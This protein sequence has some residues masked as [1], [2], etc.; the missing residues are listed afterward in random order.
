MGSAPC[1]AAATPTSSPA[2]PPRPV[3]SATMPAPTGLSVHLARLDRALETLGPG[4]VAETLRRHLEQLRPADREAFVALFETP[5][6]SCESSLLGEV[7]AMVDDLP[8]AVQ[9][10]MD[11]HWQRTHRTWRHWDDGDE[12]DDGDDGGTSMVRTSVD[13]LYRRLG[14]RFLAGDTATAVAGY[15]QLLG[16]AVAAVDEPS[17]V[18]VAGS[19]DIAREAIARLLRALLEDT[20]QSPTDCASAAV[21]A[22]DT[23]RHAVAAR[24]SPRSS[25]P[26]PTMASATTPS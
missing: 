14:E 2:G 5:A 16:A 3:P 25:T 11:D 26:D 19:D 18:H 8:A 12:W 10:L 20:S 7:A 15:R 23:Y 6:P 22:L 1:H 13:D 9:E 24:R 21:D 17:G 4:G